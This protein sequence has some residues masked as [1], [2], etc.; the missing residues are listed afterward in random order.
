MHY[1]LL[2]LELQGHLNP[3][4]TLGAELL[5]RGH[6]VTLLGSSRAKPAADRAGLDWAPLGDSAEISAGWDALGNLTG[7]AALRQ[8]GRLVE[9]T[10]AATRVDLPALIA[11]HR[12]DMLLID[13]FA[14]TG[15]VVSEELGL[16]YVVVC[17][18]LAL[19]LGSSVPPPTT[20]WSYRTGPLARLRNGLANAALNAL[21]NRSAGTPGA[22]PP[23]LLAGL[24]REWGDA[25]VTQ[26]PACFD[27]P[28]HPRPSH[29]HY[30]APWHAD[31]RD[32][33]VPFPWDRLD[34]RPLVYA[35]MGTLQNKL[36][37]VYAAIAEAARGLDVQLVLSLGSP[38]AELDV[39]P[40]ENVIVVPFAPQLQLLDR[41]S[42]VVTHA[43]LN[44]ALES[45]ARG[46]PML[47]L[48]VTNDQPGVARRVEHLGAGLVLPPSRVSARRVRQRLAAILGDPGFGERAAG[49]QRQMGRTDGVRMAADVVERVLGVAVGDT[50]GGRTSDLVV[51]DDALH[52]APRAR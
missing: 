35:S 28:D 38:N 12:I 10:A 43:G 9:Q 20:S 1:A 25:V 5:R 41:A 48:P 36:H 34:G 4:T 19:H 17:N 27:F 32:H 6:R 37:H 47:C 52:V 21:F 45:L 42:A 44:T 39:E 7:L 2:T 26:Q 14:P 40:P 50:G 49:L 22:A 18:A 15:A 16:P 30:T 11:E 51:V 23:M 8:T 31:G 3:M 33:S 29:F 24:D 13:Q 46:L